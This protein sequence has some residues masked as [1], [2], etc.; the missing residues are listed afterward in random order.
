MIDFE[1]EQLE[2]DASLKSVLRTYSDRLQR[3]KESDEEHDGWIGRLESIDGVPSDQLSRAHGRLIAFGL[4]KF[5][6][7]DRVSGIR[8]QVTTLGRRIL[9][10]PID[11]DAVAAA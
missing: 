2:E 1:R 5:E 7:T 4:L 10:P 8:Y 11:A 6:M 9:D 3:L